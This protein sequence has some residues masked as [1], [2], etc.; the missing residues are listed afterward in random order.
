VV[1][2]LSSPQ[3]IMRDAA[4]ALEEPH[5]SKMSLTNQTPTQAG[6]VGTV[7]L[8][9]ECSDA[10]GNGSWERGPQLQ[11]SSGGNRPSIYFFDDW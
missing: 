8:D 6:E 4:M 3:E 11:V 2:D 5:P 1:E 7:F 10:V 9:S